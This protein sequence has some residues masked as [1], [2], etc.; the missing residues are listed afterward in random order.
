MLCFR[1]FFLARALFY[2]YYL[3]VLY[4]DETKLYSNHT[5]HLSDDHT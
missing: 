2:S 5:N 3:Y 4:L 1:S